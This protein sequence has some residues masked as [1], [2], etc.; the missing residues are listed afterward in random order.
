MKRVAAAEWNGN[1]LYERK[2]R[3]RKLCFGVVLSAPFVVI[4]VTIPIVRGS[5]HTDGECKYE[6]TWKA[7]CEPSQGD[8]ERTTIHGWRMFLLTSQL[9]Q[10]KPF[11]FKQRH[12]RTSLSFTALAF[13]W[14]KVFIH[15]K[16]SKWWCRLKVDGDVHLTIG[17]RRQKGEEF[18]LTMRTRYTC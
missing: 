6:T 3:G 18:S 1:L 8:D 15:V 4:I 17:W 11:Y 14:F 10:W 16:S 12:Q 7:R 2:S 9:L 13:K 5:A